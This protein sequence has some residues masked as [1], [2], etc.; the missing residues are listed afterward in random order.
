[1]TRHASAALLTPLALLAALSLAGCGSP[2]AAG[3]TSGQ[4]TAAATVPVASAT[5]ATTASAPAAAGARD[6]CGLL[7]AAEVT[8]AVGAALAV[9]GP[10][11]SIGNAT[12]CT[13]GTD[14]LYV[15]VEV[16]DAEVYRVAAS[17]STTQVAGPW[18][19]GSYFTA[20]TGTS[21]A[22]L[23]GSTGVAIQVVALTSTAP[24]L[25]HVTALATAS[26]GRL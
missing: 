12:E 1:M 4:A 3:T 25:A 23:K 20:V 22:Y 19:Q 8:T 13:W 9:Q 15:Q 2:S 18:D 5:T 26:A 21:M 17:S 10:A 16:G 6:A 11:Q 14:T 7:T 24:D